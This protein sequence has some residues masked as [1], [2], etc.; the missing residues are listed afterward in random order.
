M[1]KKMLVLVCAVFLSFLTFMMIGC[2]EAEAIL[3]VTIDG[4]SSMDTV[5]LTFS[6]AIVSISMPN[7]IELETGT[8]SF[9]L[10]KDD[11]NLGNYGLLSSDDHSITI[12]LLGQTE[13]SMS[14]GAYEFRLYSGSEADPVLIAEEEITFPVWSGSS[15]A[16][17]I[18]QINASDLYMQMLGGSEPFEKADFTVFN[19]NGS[20][21]A[22]TFARESPGD[23]LEYHFGFGGSGR[24][25]IRFAKSGY[26]PSYDTFIR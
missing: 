3:G 17:D 15:R 26:K 21:I 18:Y 8:Y 16:V 12:A 9:D 11:V 25:W 10:Y 2:E 14:S 6:K 13:T 19:A 20:S 23:S 22:F 4:S 7:T 5:T 1:A 24:F